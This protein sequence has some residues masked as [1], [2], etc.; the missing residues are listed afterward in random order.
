MTKRAISLLTSLI[1]LLVSIFLLLCYFVFK[2]D[3]ITLHL[4]ANNVTLYVGQ[5]VYNYYEVTDSNA[6][7][8]FEVSEGNI[9]DINSDRI[10]GLN[11]GKVT[12]DII[13]KLENLS[14]STSIEVTVLSNSYTYSINPIENCI[15]QN[16]VLY[17]YED[18]NL[19]TV[20]V[21][22]KDWK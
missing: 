15:Y 2:T 10:L 16:G 13:A 14:Y 18:D 1:M 11:A 12:V 9:I 5:S 17:S 8:A 21:F 3:K 19:F 6:N 20:D 7:I 22:D 4:N